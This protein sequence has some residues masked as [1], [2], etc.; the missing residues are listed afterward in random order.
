MFLRK[1]NGFLISALVGLLNIF[2]S[3]G[4]FVFGDGLLFS[5]DENHCVALM[6][7]RAQGEVS[8]L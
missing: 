4:R 6:G 5:I 8:F 1:I 7:V 3:F 2:I